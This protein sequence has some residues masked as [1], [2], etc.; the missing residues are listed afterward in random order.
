MSKYDYMLAG[1][2]RNHQNIREILTALRRGGKKVYCFIDNS[3]DSDGVVID[4][5]TQDA[6]A[7]M[8]KL[9]STPDWKT[10]PTFRKIFENDMNGIREADNFLI[11]FPAGLAAHMEL[12]AAYGMGKKCFAI[13]EPEKYETLY[14]MLD[15]IYPSVDAFL[16]D[17]IGTRA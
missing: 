3:Y 6:H 4:T 14:L 2:W 11:V 13:G 16:K 10:N 17:R 9:E 15:K 8:S 12:G 7:M 5:A 1:R